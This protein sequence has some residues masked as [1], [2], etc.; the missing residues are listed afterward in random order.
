MEGIE[1]EERNA[2]KAG[3]IILLR[4]ADLIRMEEG[5][6]AERLEIALVFGLL[7]CGL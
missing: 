3:R 4:L 6:R 7:I 2:M 5:E 1:I